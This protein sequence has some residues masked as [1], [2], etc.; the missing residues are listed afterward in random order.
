MPHTAKS[1]RFFHLHLVSDATGETLT[2]VANAATVQYAD[3]QPIQHVHALV[4]NPKQLDRVVRAIEAAPGVVLFTLVNEDLRS[5]LE[6]RC[7][8]A[9]VPS[10]SVLDP[11]M[12]ALASYL[13]A[14]S[15][16]LVGGQHV[17]DADYFRRIEALNFSMLHDD[18]HLPENLN[19]ADIILLGISRTSKTPTSIYLANRGFKTANVP[20]VLGMPLPPQL[21]AATRPLVVGLIASTERIMQIRRNRLLS[22]KEGAETHYVDKA[23]IAEELTFA[24]KLCARHDW[25]VI[26]VTR[27]SIEETAAA[28]L[29]L[30]HQK[31]Q[32]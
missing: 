2:A 17:L 27:R 22:L 3:F 23:V 31:S 7:R 9:G 20:L 15:R 13:N 21:E 16:P 28:V 14:K 1:Q 26:D 12:A 11:V 24:R 4:R 18:G 19:H 10:I 30:Y 25:P 6:S 8:E 29:T 5:A 32:P